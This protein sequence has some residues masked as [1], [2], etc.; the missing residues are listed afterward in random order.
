MC[1]PSA[2]LDLSRLQTSQKMAS[3]EASNMSRLMCHMAY[4]LRCIP[5]QF[6]LNDVSGKAEFRY[7]SR[8][9]TI[10]CLIVIVLNICWRVGF[11]LLAGLWFDM[12]HAHLVPIAE[13]AQYFFILSMSVLSISLQL[14]MLFF[15]GRIQQ[16]E[17][18]FF[19]FI[20]N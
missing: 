12:T 20:L 13:R 15:H 19:V 14:S 11:F 2:F 7:G 9:N 3:L 17:N 8:W 5:Y 10:L 6:I 1:P 18:T 4:Q 16:L